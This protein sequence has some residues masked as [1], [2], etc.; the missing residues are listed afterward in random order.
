MMKHLL[1]TVSLKLIAVVC[2]LAV[3]CCAYTAEKAGAGDD[4]F[5]ALNSGLDDVDKELAD[6]MKLLEDKGTPGKV[7]IDATEKEFAVRIRWDDMVKGPGEYSVDCRCEI[8]DKLTIHLEFDLISGKVTGNFKG[9]VK[10]WEDGSEFSEAN[11]SGRISQGWIEKY[12]R[13]KFPHLKFGGTA[14]VMM[15][16]SAKGYQINGAV[17]KEIQ[18]KFEGHAFADDDQGKFEMNWDE[19]EKG[20]K[21]HWFVLKLKGDR[22]PVRFPP[23]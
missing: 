1:G 23:I 13:A 4:A 17:S 22:F 14:T 12:P 8:C 18:A 7:V 15:D 16:M 19:V 5:D 11:F 6:L 3:A 2:V 9:H 20:P 10:G 21:F